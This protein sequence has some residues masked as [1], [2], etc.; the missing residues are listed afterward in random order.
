[1]LLEM[2]RCLREISAGRVPRQL[3][4]ADRRAG[5]APPVRTSTAIDRASMDIRSPPEYTTLHDKDGLPVRRATLIF[6]LGG[7]RRRKS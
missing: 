3:R 6:A 7:L 1:M 2:A 4:A 5:A